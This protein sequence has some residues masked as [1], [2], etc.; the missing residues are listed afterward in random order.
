MYTPLFAELGLMDCT[1]LGRLYAAKAGLGQN[2]TDLGPL[3]GPDGRGLSVLGAV[4]HPGNKTGMVMEY[5]PSLLRDELSAQVFHRD[6]HQSWHEDTERIFAYRLG[7]W[8]CGVFMN[9]RERIT[10]VVALSD[11]TAFSHQGI[12]IIS[13]KLE[14]T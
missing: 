7:L 10:T 5:L 13:E 1:E 4:F 3:L 9:Y 6:S 14:T 2:F 12:S 11:N 8:V